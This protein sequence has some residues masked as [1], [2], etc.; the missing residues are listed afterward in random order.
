VKKKF[1]RREF[2]A[3]AGVAMAAAVLP[4]CTTA[5]PTTAPAATAQAPI[6][7]PTVV[8][9]S[10]LTGTFR[11]TTNS[12]AE[13]RRPAVEKF[14]KDNYPNMKLQIEVTPTSYWEKLL[15]QIASKDVADMCYMHEQ[16]FMS[17]ASQG[18]LLP[19]DQYMKAK[20][21]IGDAT[22]YPMKTFERNTTY[23]GQLMAM[24]VGFAVLMIRYNKSIFDKAGVK[25]PTPDWTWDDFSKIAASL[26]KDTN[27][28]KTPETWG[29]IGW[30]PSWLP[31]WWPLMQSNGAYHFNDARDKCILNEDPGVQTLD[32]M[33]KTWIGDMRSSPTPAAMT[34]LQ[35]GTSKLFEGGLAA[36]DYTLSQNVASSLKAI[37]NRF[38]MGLETYPS[39]PKGRFV[40]TGGTS[41]A[42]PMGAKYPEITW[43]LIRYLTGDEEA[44]KTAAAYDVG[45]PLIRL[46][47]VLK[48]NAP[49]GPLADRWK[50]IVT[51][52]NQK[53]G[54]VVQ[55]AP[56]GEYESIC[57]TNLQKMADGELNAKQAAENI[58]N[59]ANKALKDAPK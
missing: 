58:T 54:T 12:E 57:T 5:T 15:A 45:N 47:Y 1:S 26:T 6:A 48:Y 46:D 38:E 28:D 27:N 30:N 3:A 53:N 21:L 31:G 14:F 43:D 11:F 35:S 22:Q 40:R 49:E 33:R 42:A 37:D 10:T 59:E 25:Y 50:S 44:N 16:R 36:M 20:P 32:S 34:Q 13:S 8:G 17:F 18:A 55:Y 4:A 39:G 2:L 24:P 51:E 23:K 41:Y 19:L 29:W 9:P 52:A 7:K 56:I